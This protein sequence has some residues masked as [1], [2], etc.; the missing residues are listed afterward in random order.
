[1]GSS[2]QRS[3]TASRLDAN[4]VDAEP[5]ADGAVLPSRHR[6]LRGDA[7]RLPSAIKDR[8]VDVVVTSPP[9]WRKRNY[10]VEGQIGQEAAA[11]EYVDAMTECVEG[12]IRVLRETASVFLNIGDSYAARSLQGIPGRLEH[13]LRERGWVIR[14][15]IIW[16]KAGGVPD[17]ARD[18]LTPRHEYVLH[19]VR[20]RGYYYDLFGFAEEYSRGGRGANPGDVWQF[21]AELNGGGHLAPFPTEL[22]KRALRLACPEHVCTECG[23]PWRRAVRRTTELNMS[24]P[25]A[26]RAQELFEQS[27]LT[28]AHLRAVQA[29]GIS[30]AGKARLTQA[31]TDRNAERV[32]ELSAEAKAVLGGYFREYTFAKRVSD[33]WRECGCDAPT[34]PGVVLDPF[35]GTGT[36]LRAAADLGRSSVGVDLDPTAMRDADLRGAN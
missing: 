26:R 13:A 25:Q 5:T 4:E 18:R 15:R 3:P 2:C 17:P 29:T 23:R 21:D 9:Y 20:G 10:G 28:D 36:V 24:R 32:R 11:D 22:A 7:R 35:A 8:S 33:G 27:S 31:G 14:N 16:A 6:T 34:A 12:W 19:L 1:M 30:D